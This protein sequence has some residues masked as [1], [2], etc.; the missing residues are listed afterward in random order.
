MRATGFF[1]LS[2]VLFLSTSISGVAAGRDLQLIEAVKRAD[3]VAV[4]ALIKQGVNVNAGQG[5]GRTALHWAAYRSDQEAVNVLIEAGARVNATTDLRITPLWV[6]CTSGSTAVIARLLAAGADPNIAP[7]TDGTPLMIASRTGNAEAVKL[8]LAHGADV[9]AKEASRG[10]TALMWAVAEQH[11]DV[12]QVLL[13]RGADVHARS[14]SSRRYVLLCC[15]DFEGDPGGGDYVEEGGDTPL[16]F[17]ARVGDVES[18]KLLLAAGAHIEDVAPT[19]TSPLVLAAHSDQGAFAA[20]LLDQGANPDSDGAG[21]TALHAAVLRGNLNLVKALLG[22]G[23]NPNPRQMKGSPARRY[24]GYGLDKRMIGAT[25]FLLATRAAQLDAMRV[26]AANGGDVNLGLENG[27]TPLMAAAMRQV[28]GGR[29]AET[30]IVQAL[31]LAMELG[32]KV[33]TP[34][35]DGDTALHFAATRRLDTVVQFLV[36]SGATVNAKNNKGQTPLAATLVP[37]P[38]AK[39]AGQ[40]TFEEYNFLSSHTA[41]TTELLR[42]LGATE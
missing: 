1:G 22:H 29:F 14:S 19:G 30:R 25:P 4:R 17:A 39:G 38:P 41:G 31:K 15:Q 13:A 32:A 42:K 26:L 6:A 34:N 9:N 27:T 8:L 2:L 10:Q 21:Y 7:E 36:D 12:V 24:S 35:T 20:F 40:A 23:A 5:D 16:L 33:T 18:A 28:R 11:P 3:T 37:V